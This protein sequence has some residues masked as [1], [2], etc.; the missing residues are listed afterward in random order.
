MAMYFDG[1]ICAMQRLAEA[2]GLSAVVVD[3]ARRT[4]GIM[5][6]SIFR[7]FDGMASVLLALG[8]CE[9]ASTVRQFIADVERAEWSRSLP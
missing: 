9:G 2:R 8:D 6:M 3:S 7:V 5:D 1:H 4:A